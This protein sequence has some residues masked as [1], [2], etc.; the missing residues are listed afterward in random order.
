MPWTLTGNIRGPQGQA[1]SA[2]P[3]G[4]SQ[5][6]ALWMDAASLVFTNLAAAGVEVAASGLRARTVMDLAG[7][8][9]FRVGGVLA[10]V[11]ATGTKIRME[12]ST[13]NTGSWAELKAAGASTDP[14]MPLTGALGAR[15]GVW[16]D[17]AAASRVADIVLRPW[18]FGGNGTADPSIS[19][20]YVEVR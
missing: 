1:G 20:L 15:A 7:A 6:A 18:V 17:I 9:Q 8:T 16:T 10:V 13:S 2:G 14:D 3:A 19:A 12:Y 11:G 5:R 4:V